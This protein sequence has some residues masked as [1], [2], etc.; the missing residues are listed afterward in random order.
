MSLLVLLVLALLLAG[1]WL[2]WGLG[3]AML[4]SGVVLAIV[5]GT[6]S[7]YQIRVI[8]RRLTL[9]ESLANR[10]LKDF[11]G[12]VMLIDE[13]GVIEQ[14]NPDI[15]QHVGYAPASLIG[16]R[17]TLL[18]K[19]PL[20]GGLRRAIG[21][22][23]ARQFPWQGVLAFRL[24]DGEWCYRDTV[25][26][27]D[28]EHGQGHRRLLIL[29]HDVTTVHRDHLHDRILLDRLQGTLSRLPS[30]VFESRQDGLGR[31]EFL[32]LSA[33]LQSLCGLSPAE[34][35]ED[36]SRLLERV[37]PEDRYRLAASLAQSS[38]SLAPW[39]L[40]FR[41]S[42][43][44]GTCWLEGRAI[45]RRRPDGN[46]HWDGLLID[47]S[48]RKHT[49]QMIQ[50]LVGTDMLTGVLNRRAFFEQGEAVLARASRR[51]RTL[52]LAMLDLDHF[53]KLNDTHGHAAGDLA[54]ENF[55]MTC[56]EC[57]RP[58][59]IFARIGGEEF[60]VLLVDTEPEETW[61]ILERLRQAVERIEL[62]IDGHSVHFTVSIGL[63]I[64]E[65]DGSLDGALSNA[66]HALYRAKE[67]GR[68]RV[69]GPPGFLSAQG[70]AEDRLA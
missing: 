22:V 24:S 36:A 33:G 28:S 25:I 57:L 43:P 51:K 14:V 56:L 29:Q 2:W 47:I 20:G 52:P 64:L 66:D 18:D 62:D 53:K 11:P 54:L 61:G 45:S 34:V 30:A 48:E 65:P 10:L 59:D 70:A 50:R 41:L 63:T 19:E 31:L 15:E 21:R 69:C 46:T 68:N 44:E 35:I 1:G 37:H 5:L 3:P 32:Y 26:L 9:E 55:A 17:V 39:Y 8:D 42:L 38:V 4:V 40:E 27:P 16:R 12:A 13:Q 67:A 7:L 60:V 58:Y 49:E 23:V 6:F